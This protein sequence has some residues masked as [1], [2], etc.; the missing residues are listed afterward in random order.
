VDSLTDRSAGDEVINRLEWL[1][2]TISYKRELHITMRDLR[3][4]IAY[5]ISR[6]CACG[7]IDPL[8]QK[9]QEQPEKYWQYYYFN[10]TSPDA[11]G[12]NDRLIKLMRETDLAQVSIP[13]IDRDLYFG[14]HHQKD[15]LE[16]SDRQIGLLDAFNQFKI[17]IP[18]YDLTGDIK[19]KLKNR[20]RSFVRHQYFEG[21][22]DFK[23][24]LP[25]QSLVDFHGLLSGNGNH[26]DSIQKA[27]QSLA[28]AISISEGCENMELATNF[29][30]LKSS[31]VNDPISESYRRFPLEGFELYVNKS[32]SLVQFI[33]DESDSLVFRNIEDQYITLTVSLDLYEMLYFIKQGFSPSINDM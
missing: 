12:T 7:D 10:I 31:R 28:Q 26:H 32:E 14:L 3:S 27:K 6:D 5:L 8:Y 23:R 19:A 33:E 1:M 29:L 24:R 25:Y 13:S 9:Y 20:H 17:L 18:A 16:F 15:Y 22:F 11:E 30:L 21:K 2:R 4:F